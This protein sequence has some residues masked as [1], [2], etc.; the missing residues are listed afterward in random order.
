MNL[1]SHRFSQNVNKKLSGFLHSHYR[2]EILTIF[3]SHFGRNDDFI[4]SFWNLL[5]FSTRQLSVVPGSLSSV[6]GW[7]A[8][9][10]CCD[11][12]AVFKNPAPFHW[13]NKLQSQV[14]RIAMQNNGRWRSDWFC[15]VHLPEILEE[16]LFG[17]IGHVAGGRDYLALLS[18]QPSTQ[19][20][21][22]AKKRTSCWWVICTF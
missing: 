17:P 4:N 22:R 11:S 12:A 3:G 20:R 16:Y 8:E 10:W 21:E 13:R 15:L 9:A 7:Q 6:A 14:I 2:A 1:W 19:F 5:T 18:T